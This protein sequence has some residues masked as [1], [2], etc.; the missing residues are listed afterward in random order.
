MFKFHFAV[1]VSVL[2]VIQLCADVSLLAQ[3]PT[4][5]EQS[6]WEAIAESVT[7]HRDQYG[8]PHV[9][10]PT[11]ASVV[12]GYNY[13]RAEDE[14][15]RMETSALTG[16][17]RAAEK[18]GPTAFTSDR[19]VHLFDILQL[20]QAEYKRCPDSFK[21]ILQA[22]ADAMNYYMFKNPDRQTYTLERYE[23]W[24]PLATQRLMNVGIISLSPEQAE[25]QRIMTA[26]RNDDSDSLDQEYSQTAITDF[27]P[28]LI[29]NKID[30]S[31]MWAI[32]PKKTSTGN[33]MLFINPHIPLHEVY[34]AHLHSD[35][36]YHFSGGSAYG[37][38]PVPIMGHNENLGWSLTVNYPDI[39]DVYRESFDHPDDPLQYRFG[40][41]WQTANQRTATVK[42]KVGRRLIDREIEIIETHNGPV[43]FDNGKQKYVI[44]V[45]QLEK[46]G[47][48]N[49]FYQMGR[50]KNLKQFQGAVSELALVFHNIMY[51]DVEGNI[52]YVYNAAIPKRSQKF[53][54]GTI[55]DGA[56]PE[57]RWQG[58]HPME[59]LPQLLNPECGWMQNCNSSPFTT[60]QDADNPVANDFPN[61]IGRRDRDDPRVAISKTILNQ[62]QKFDFE[63]WSAAAWDRRVLN[64]DT[65]IPILDQKHAELKQ[66][67]QQQFDSLAPLLSELKSWNRQCD[68][69]SV[70]SALFM[71][72][73]QKMQTIAQ[74]DSAAE[75]ALE[76][77]IEAKTEL[78]QNFQTWK[79]PYG[80]VF[81]HQ[82]PD[83]SGNYA[84]DEGTSIPIH[85]GNPRVGMVFTYLTRRPPGSK[86]YYGYHGHSFVSVVEFDKT[87]LHA[88]SLVPF[89]ASRDPESKHYFDQAPLFATGKFKPA[90]FAKEDVTANTSRSYHPGQ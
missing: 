38:Y 52:W 29:R 77:L 46:G 51:A 9:Y 72:W 15:D 76:K 3:E 66:K 75:Q 28:T 41:T 45:P 31:N 62:D 78:E 18:L 80:D 11:D 60:S 25:L 73:F 90:W 40:D 48:A 2:A 39:I 34:E 50:A 10:G 36:G 59:D 20:A 35:E 53:D 5:E 64:A 47:L 16:I 17:G 8:V 67:N 71:L 84:G 55:Q 19:A 65:W 63:S 21:Q 89:G 6:R 54:W 43:I 12:F 27:C 81:R 85:G 37:S 86:R 44:R 58:I 32:A 87:F 14:F 33:A 56:N 57:T 1:S 30:G 83:S 79:V 42:V 61:Y 23:P 13:A 69:D 24:H 68:A 4:K 22:Y 49:Q 70:P 26:P 82:R 88:R 74:S 7:I